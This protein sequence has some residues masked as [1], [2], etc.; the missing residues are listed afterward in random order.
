M[1]QKF[2]NKSIL[3]QALAAEIAVQI[4]TAIQLFGD[5]RILLSGGSTPAGVYHLL[6]TY[7][8]DWSKVLVGLVDERFVPVESAYSNEQFIQ[9]SLLQG[10][11]FR[12]SFHGMVID[13]ENYERNVQL[14]N[15]L[16][17]PFI[18]RT[19][20]VLL[21]MGEDGHTASLFPEDPASLT[22]LANSETGIFN[23]S[24]P[25]MPTQRITC[26]KEM[27][28]HA[29][30]V[31]LMVTGSKKWSV[32]ESAKEVNYPISVF[33]NQLKRLQLFYSEN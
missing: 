3:E 12:A 4:E 23:T 17:Q 30:H 24:A 11:A 27:L 10:F 18:E 29:H 22:L 26:S 19:D 16:Y 5:A 9:K 7:S 15:Q 2:E 33:L 20:I 1:I 28:C 21:G 8:I 14:A 31:Y 25:V 13:S 32:L 6:S